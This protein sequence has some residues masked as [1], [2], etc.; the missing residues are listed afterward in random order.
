MSVRTYKANIAVPSHVTVEDI[1]S[2][3]SFL[4]GIGEATHSS[5][6]RAP[7][8]ISFTWEADEVSSFEHGYKLCEIEAEVNQVLASHGW[9]TLHERWVRT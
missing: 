1:N 7:V 6:R 2:V 3:L 4:T 5:L 8:V 9:E